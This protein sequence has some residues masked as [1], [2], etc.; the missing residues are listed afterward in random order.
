MYLLFFKCKAKQSL[1]NTNGIDNTEY[2]SEFYTRLCKEV[3]L[4]YVLPKDG[5]S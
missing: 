1:S 3:V 5:K 4:F 2:K